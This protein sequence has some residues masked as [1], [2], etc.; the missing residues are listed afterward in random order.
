MGPEN[1]VVKFHY[2]EWHNII[3]FYWSLQTFNPKF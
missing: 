2:E 1:F 3:T